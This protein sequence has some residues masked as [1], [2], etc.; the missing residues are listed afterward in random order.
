[1]NRPTLLRRSRAYKGEGILGYALRLTELNGYSSPRQLRQ[2]AGIDNDTS[3]ASPEGLAALAAVARQ[4]L[5]AASAPAEESLR[6]HTLI[7]PIDAE[8]VPTAEWT[9]A[10]RCCPRCV[11]E[12][13]F[14]EGHWSLPHMIACPL[15]RYLAV[16]SCSACKKLLRW[17]RP[18]LLE[19]SCGASIGIGTAR[20]ATASELAFLDLIRCKALGLDAPKANR[21]R[22]P[23]EDLMKMTL[24]QLVDVADTLARLQGA[25]TG[26]DKRQVIFLA[27]RAL[28]DWPHSFL[29]VLDPREGGPGREV[30]FRKCLSRCLRALCGANI[31]Q[32]SHMDFMG[33]VMVEYAV[34]QWNYRPS[35]LSRYQAHIPTG[36]LNHLGGEE[37]L[38]STLAASSGMVTDAMLDAADAARYLCCSMTTIEGLVRSGSLQGNVHA[39]KWK[40]E[41]NS[42]R[43]FRR[44]FVFL[45]EIARSMSKTERTV[46][47]MCQARGIRIFTPRT[48]K[49][50]GKALYIRAADVDRL[51]QALHKHK[52]WKM[53]VGYIPFRRYKRA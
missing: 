15:H 50:S 38:K 42:L 25:N 51:K 53:E 24:P 5:P 14:I 10:A 48:A 19:C 35:E 18:G 36:V 4:T 12:V 28:S 41:V 21:E 44:D 40:V 52:G 17:H 1:M 32:S 26:G 6:A 34:R 16:S 8:F 33:A 11:K 46:R 49:I 9:L 43:S 47:M 37:V 3:L 22:F 39:A 45:I 29:K 23:I 30:Q 31:A 13:G 7:R 2:F 27:A 20:V